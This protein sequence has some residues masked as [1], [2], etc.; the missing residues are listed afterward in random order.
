MYLFYNRAL[1]ASFLFFSWKIRIGNWDLRSAE[2]V[3]ISNIEDAQIHQDYDFSTSYYDVA[4]LTVPPLTL[5]NVSSL[6]YSD[7][8]PNFPDYH[9]IGI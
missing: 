1:N 6:K 4:I 7:N 9:C 8:F 3:V 5:S 2:S